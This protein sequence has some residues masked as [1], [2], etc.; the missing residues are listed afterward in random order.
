LVLTESVPVAIAIKD[1]GVVAV[2]DLAVAVIIHVVAGVDRIGVAGGLVVGAVGATAPNAGVTVSIGVDPIR[3]VAVLV[4][5]VTHDIER[6]ARFRS[7][8]VASGDG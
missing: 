7:F 8:I 2:V 1:G 5:P 6:V 3:T 4:D